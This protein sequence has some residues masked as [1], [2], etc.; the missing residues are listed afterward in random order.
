LNSGHEGHHCSRLSVRR[1]D[2]FSHHSIAWQPWAGILLLL[3]Q[4]AAGAGW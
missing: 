1:S 2:L 4:A 3:V